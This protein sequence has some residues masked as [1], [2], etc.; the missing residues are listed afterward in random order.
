M[1]VASW[2]FNTSANP[3]STTF[4]TAECKFNLKERLASILLLIAQL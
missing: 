3:R 1:L 4:V 2:R